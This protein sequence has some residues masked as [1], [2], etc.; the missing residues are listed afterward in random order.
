MDILKKTIAFLASFKLATVILVLL[1]LLTFFGTLEQGKSTLFD[2]QQSYFTSFFVVHE[3]G[4]VVAL[5][6]RG[7]LI[8]FGLLTLAVA[9]YLTARR[10]RPAASPAGEADPAEAGAPAEAWVINLWWIGGILTA[11]GVALQLAAWAGSPTV[12]PLP[13]AMIL[14][15]LLLLNLLLGGLIRM[16]AGKSTIGVFIVHIGI[17]VLLVGSYIEHQFAS[18]G[19][20]TLFEGQDSDEFVSYTDWEV[21]VVEPLPGGKTREVVI[22]HE[23]FS[24]L[25][26]DDTATFEN[27]NLPFRLTLSG[28]VR[29]ARPKAVPGT[30]GGAGGFVLE[31]LAPV[32]AKAE[33]R[34]RRNL[35]GMYAT[36]LPEGAEPQRGILWAGQQFPWKVDVGGRSFEVHMRPRRWKLPFDIQLE[37]FVHEVHPGTG[38]ARRFS[39]YVTK[40]DERGIAREVHITMNEPLRSDG[41]TLYQSGWGPQGAPPGTPLFSTFSVVANPSDRV[42]LWAC[43]IIG[44]GLLL[45]FLRKLFLFLRAQSRR[46]AAEANAS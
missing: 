27:A 33:K 25:D 10:Q 34:N 13:G 37:R 31:D 32:T 45:H 19:H 6:I 29:N 4:D 40:T 38:M 26:G 21:A 14:L 8:L 16:R 3:V 1:L 42:P 11:L 2:V 28:Y 22:P 18:N 41:Y 20:M 46:N 24:T 5:A 9:F 43:V 12:L 35:A 44:A 7:S 15:P 36:I 30:N 17:V 23:R 39:S